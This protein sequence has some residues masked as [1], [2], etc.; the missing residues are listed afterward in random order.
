MSE[1]TSLDITVLLP[2][3]RVVIFSQDPDTLAAAEALAHDWRFAR[4]EISAQEGT[5]EGAIAYTSQ[6][7][8]P[9]LM[10]VQTDAIDDGFTARLEDLA[11][12]C[13]EGTA[14]IVIGP[15]NDVYLY[16]KLVDM[17]VSDYLVKP[18]T[19]DILAGVIAKTLI[20]K[21]GVSGSRLI[22]LVGA[23][24]GLG[25]SALAQALA[26]GISDLMEQKTLLMDLAAGWSSMSVGMGFEPVTTLA[27]AVKAAG[28]GDQDSIKRMLYKASDRLDVLAHGGDELLDHSVSEAQI[29]T[30]LDV[31]LARTPVVVA[32]LSQSPVGFRRVVLSRA[33][34][35]IVTTAP[36]LSSLRLARSL[37][38]EIKELRGGSE[39]AVR[40][41]VTMQGAAGALEVPGKD[42][43][44]A[45][46][47]KPSGT[48]PFDPKLFIR[49]EN[50]AQPLIKT[51]EGLALVKTILFPLVQNVISAEGL[52]AGPSSSA[53]S[54][55][56][57]GGL[58]GKFSRGK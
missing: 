39:E 1:N 30:L 25:T 40:L 42:I 49:S 8:S 11:G 31:M 38:H 41:L 28:K 4:V 3:S 20:S 53:I 23:K 9:D 54:A 56:F 47:F 7:A 35:I 15:V 12:N 27:E 55:G 37:L 26:W 13:D 43:G 22:G 45:L 33:N 18:M 17:G 2:Q 16:R 5:V 29:E 46:D 34:L 6:Y 57:L 48:V 19:T 51:P 52:D 24:G 32:D 10:I 14:A 44:Q 21:R 58:L 36:L 50:D